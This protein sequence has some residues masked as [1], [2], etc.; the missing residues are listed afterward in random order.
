MM[1]DIKNLSCGYGKKEIIKN[2]SLSIEKGDI[3][4]MIGPNGAGKTTL[5][6]AI[7]KI[8][9]LTSG[10]ILFKNKNILNIPTLNLAQSIATVPQFTSIPFSF[11]VGELVMMGRFPHIKRLQNPSEHD[12]NIVNRSMEI[13]DIT[14]QKERNVNELSGGEIQRAVLAQA[15]AQEPELLLLDEPTA[16]LDIK[17]QVDLL[18]IIQR[19]NKE[20]SLTVIMINHDLNLSS[21]FCK[22]ITLLDEGKIIKIGKPDE[23][24]TSSIIFDIY[25]TKVN[26][27]KNPV[28]SKPHVYITAE[29]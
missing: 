18:N 13:T 15:L 3:L 1:L 11:T 9:K 5:L 7:T 10:N 14:E 29:K 4:G 6:R 23:V 26:V 21:E 25:K 27:T 16:H 8:L 22:R 28:S 12:I 17:H 19:L 2:I 20:T 24:L